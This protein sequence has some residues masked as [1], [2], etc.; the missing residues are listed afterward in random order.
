MLRRLAQI[1]PARTYAKFLIRSLG[2]VLVSLVM[3]AEEDFGGQALG[4]PPGTGGVAS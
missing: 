3:Y 4:R 2:L 1:G